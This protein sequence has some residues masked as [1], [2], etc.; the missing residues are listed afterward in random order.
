VTDYLILFLIV[1][2]IHLT[3]AFTPP[4]WP[5]IALYSLTFTMP[6]PLVVVSAALAAA[7]GRYSLAHASWLLRHRLGERIRAKLDRVYGLLQRRKRSRVLV[8]GIFVLSP[9][10]SALLFEA[11]GMAGLRLIGPTIAYF[12]GRVAFYSFYAFTARTIAEQSL[13]E[14][15]RDYMISPLGIVVQ[16]GV[17]LLV[18][19]L[20]FVDWTKWVARR[21]PAQEA[22]ANESAD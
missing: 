17:L 10:S 5:V 15:L 21:P 13:G 18:A 12:A 7:V 16:V 3:P 22:A 4:T 20:I 19:A 6:V 11:A 8:L 9:L 1:L 14:V 2:G